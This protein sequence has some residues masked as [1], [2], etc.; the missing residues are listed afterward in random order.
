MSRA[1]QR[2]A[3]LPA[4][5]ALDTLPG[6]VQCFRPPILPTVP[7]IRAVPRAVGVCPRAWV[8]GTAG[9]WRS[10]HDVAPHSDD[11]AARRHRRTITSGTS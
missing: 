1:A 5:M 4:T 6:A 7:I 8:G 9:D 10:V 2:D 3:A 11:D